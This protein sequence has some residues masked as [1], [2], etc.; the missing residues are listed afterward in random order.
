MHVH[1]CRY[2]LR[3]SG[4][5]LGA[6]AAALA[7]HL[8]HTQAERFPT[9]LAAFPRHR[10]DCFCASAPPVLSLPLARASADY[11]TALTLGHDV[12]AR[13]SIANFEQLRLEVL[14]SGWWEEMV[15]PVVKSDA[16]RR[17]SEALEQAGAGELIALARSAGQ[18]SAERRAAER[19]E[20]VPRS[21]IETALEHLHEVYT[22]PTVRCAAAVLRAVPRASVP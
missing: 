2:G 19:G 10:I 3:F 1:A 7:T 6:G 21:M 11:I 18:A 14:T 20:P 12:V 15:D 13:A 16:F 8:L 4:H 9:L 5:S 22:Q 17:V